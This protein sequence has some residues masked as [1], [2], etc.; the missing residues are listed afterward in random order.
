VPQPVPI[1]LVVE[2]Q[3]PVEVRTRTPSENRYAVCLL[4]LLH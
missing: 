4:S 2:R 3:P 1:E